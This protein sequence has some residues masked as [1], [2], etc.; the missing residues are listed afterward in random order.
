LSFINLIFIL[1]LTNFVLMG[2][3]HDQGDAEWIAIKGQ[4]RG[5]NDTPFGRPIPSRP[6]GRPGADR[7]SGVFG[8]FLVNFD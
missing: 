5:H 7:P 6:I 3:F 2:E 1:K 4:L 8:F